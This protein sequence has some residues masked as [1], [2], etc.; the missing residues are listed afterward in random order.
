MLKKDWRFQ[1]GAAFLLLAVVF[2]AIHFVVFRDADYIGKFVIAQLGF[3][4]VSVFL[5]TV[6]LNQL[7]A[8]REK[9][10]LLNKMNMVIGAFYSEVGNE[11]LAFVELTAELRKKFQIAPNWQNDD[12]QSAEKLASQSTFEASC[13]KERL[14]ALKDF[15]V[16][17]RGFLL[18]LLANPNLLEHDSFTEL[19]WA[20]LHL[21]EE[22][23]CRGDIGALPD[24]DVDHLLGDVRRAL[25]AVLVEWLRYMRHLQKGYPY[26][27][28]LAVRMCPLDPECRP[29]V[30]S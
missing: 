19:L 4:P 7:L 10:A 22:L 14:P 29:E 8:K 16:G 20:V 28:S 13:K 6:V 1:W 30:R 24:S 27:F 21:T 18:A 17:K 15:L 3:L 9:L 2:N 26:L 11:L 25:R 23:A 5:V 12:F